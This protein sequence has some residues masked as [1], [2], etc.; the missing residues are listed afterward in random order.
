MKKLSLFLVFGLLAI[1]LS[2]QYL[3]V[4]IVNYAEDTSGRLLITHF[5]D[6]IRNSPSYTIGYAN[7]EPHFKII[8]ETM[9][10]WKGDTEYE[11]VS[12][13][14]HYTILINMNELD[15]YCTS[16]LGFVGRDV[17][18]DVAYQIYSALDNYVESFAALAM[19]STRD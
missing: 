16:Q 13:I 8:F 6:I 18:S 2:A 3:P 12:T 17:L 19:D 15:I 1:C 9:D 7:N 4:E 5:R 10:R 14:Y 11:G